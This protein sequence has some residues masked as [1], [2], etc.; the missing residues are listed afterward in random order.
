[1][2][3]APVPRAPTPTPRRAPRLRP[4]VEDTCAHRIRHEV[5]GRPPGRNYELLGG[6]CIFSMTRCRTS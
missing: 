5:A 4:V 1:V 6:S 2:L 3:P